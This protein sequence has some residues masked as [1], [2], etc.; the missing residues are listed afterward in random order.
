MRCWKLLVVLC[1]LLADTV[2]QARPVGSSV[3]AVGIL[4][5]QPTH[6]PK[7]LEKFEGQVGALPIAFGTGFVVREDGYV[8][9][10]L[11][12]VRR[13]QDRL[14]EIE[15]PVKHIVVWLNVPA[16]LYKQAEIVGTDTGNDLAVLKLKLLSPAEALPVLQLT[17]QSLADGAEV[18]AAGYPER[19]AGSLVV[20]SGTFARTP[21]AAN[22]AAGDE[23]FANI[24]VENGT[25][26]GPLYLQD[27]S[28]IGV[29]IARSADRGMAGFV[30]A[31]HVIDLLA[32]SGI[33]PDHP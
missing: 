17:A 29:V 22:G 16:G 33:S 10:A 23:E 25:S 2:A 7:S 13:A 6:L 31:Q 4:A 24:R 19:K 14:A 20:T 8:V 11:H 5:V 30:P 18:W 26:G 1:L 15:A 32:R 21:T 9:T 12:V 27:G 28:V 3:V